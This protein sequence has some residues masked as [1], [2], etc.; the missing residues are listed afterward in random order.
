VTPRALMLCAATLLI[1]AACS[2]QPKVPQAVVAGGDAGGM[3]RAEPSDE[4]LDAS[5]LKAAAQDAVTHGLQALV[6]LRHGHIVYERYGHGVNGSSDEDL[7]EFAQVLV[8][9]ATG[10]GVREG[11]SLPLHN[12]FDPAKLRDAIESSAHQPYAQYLSTKL[13]RRLNAAPAWIAYQAGAPV[14][15]DCCFHARLLD[16]MRIANLLVLDGFFEGKQLVPQGWVARMRAPIA[17]DGQHGFGVLLP[18]AA[19]GA[20][21]FA[22]DDVFFLRGPEHWRMWLVPSLK[23]AVLFGAEVDDKANAVPWDET[24][25]LNLVL[26]A[27]SDSPNPTDPSQK[28]KGLVPGH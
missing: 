20:E 26:R 17:A 4:H 14:P 21:S 27:A 25:V 1:L 8:A 24:R 3:P 18:A 10:I 15:A 2:R 9:L 19:H 5:A 16:W 11:L 28:L 6:V 12:G 13:W 23:L 22:A 7:G